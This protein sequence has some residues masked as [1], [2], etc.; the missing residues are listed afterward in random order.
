D[1]AA[2]DRRAVRLGGLFSRGGA[3][4]PLRELETQPLDLPL[5]RSRLRELLLDALDEL[6]TRDPD[7]LLD[8]AQEVA[9]VPH[10]PD[11]GLA[12][13][14]LDPAYSRR[15]PL[16]GDEPEW[17]DLPGAREV[18]AAAQ[19]HAE[20]SHPD[21]SNLLAVLLPEERH[22]SGADRLVDRHDLGGQRDVLE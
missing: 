6:G 8:T 3:T 9:P 22:R 2:D 5:E 14:G 4:A 15:D 16:L 20:V 21:D 1:P 11:R 18:R 10:P 13:E 19:L 12:R 17:A 7:G